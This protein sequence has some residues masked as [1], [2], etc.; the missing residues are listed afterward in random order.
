[1]AEMVSRGATIDE[2]ESLYRAELPRFVRAAAAIVDDDELYAAL[3]DGHIAGAAMDVF[4]DEPVQPE[5][6]FVQLPNVLV[7]PHLGGATRDVLRHQSEMIVDGIEALLR[8]EAP[9]FIVNAQVLQANRDR[10]PPAGM[11]G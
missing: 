6:R 4:R 10:K 2:L 8:G 3:Q 1:M 9:R 11:D 7:S 5:N